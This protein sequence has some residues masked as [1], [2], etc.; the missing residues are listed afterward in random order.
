VVEV[1]EPPTSGSGVFLW[2]LDHKLNVR[3][4]PGNERLVT[5][6]SFVVLR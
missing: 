4:S 6:K 1:T 3:R 2:V 5:V